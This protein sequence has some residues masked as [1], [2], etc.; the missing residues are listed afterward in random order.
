ML[1]GDLPAVGA[2]NQLIECV[3][4]DMG[5][6]QISTSVL[7]L[8]GSEIIGTRDIGR[9]FM[10]SFLLCTALANPTIYNHEFNGACK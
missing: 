1:T 4:E 3:I 9:V 2:I 7:Q 8:V 10:S 6:V 5:N